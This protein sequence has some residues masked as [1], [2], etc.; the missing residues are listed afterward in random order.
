VAAYRRD[1]DPD[2]LER[3][4]RELD[5]AEIEAD[6]DR[7]RP[8]LPPD[9]VRRYLENLPAWWSVPSGGS[10]RPGDGAL[11]RIRV[12]GLSQVKVQP[13]RK[14][15]TTFWPKRLDLMRSRWSGREESHQPDEPRARPCAVRGGVSGCAIVEAC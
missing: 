13:T 1:R 8:T 11:E 3:T 15:S 7:E 10:T 9:E 5:A 6:A 14:H 2:A 12:L 4:M